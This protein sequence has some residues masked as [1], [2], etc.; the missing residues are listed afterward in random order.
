MKH[1]KEERIK[2]FTPPSNQFKSKAWSKQIQQKIYAEFS[3]NGSDDQTKNYLKA[4]KS[5]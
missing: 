3:S 5:A 2:V 1:H 4:T